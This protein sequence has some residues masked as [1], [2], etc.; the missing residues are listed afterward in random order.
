MA[1]PQPMEYNSEWK[2]IEIAHDETY[3]FELKEWTNSTLG[4][5]TLLDCLIIKN[6]FG[7][8]IGIGD[9]SAEILKPGFKF[10]SHFLELARERLN[11][12]TFTPQI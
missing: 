1:G 8:A 11:L 10:N 12:Y 4:G 6:W 7:Y 2:S 3:P 9:S 5:L